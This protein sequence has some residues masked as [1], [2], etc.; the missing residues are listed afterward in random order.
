MAK[1]ITERNSAVD[2]AVMTFQKNEMD[3]YK[4]A[5]DKI[6]LFSI[7]LPKFTPIKLNRKNM[8]DVWMAFLKDPLNDEM[9]K[10]EEIHKALD[11]LKEISADKEVREFYRLKRETEFVLL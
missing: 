10:V 4:I 2:E 9:Q 1:S 6:R 7:E 3:D 8:L 5:S 11:T